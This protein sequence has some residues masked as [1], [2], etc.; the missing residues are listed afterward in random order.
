MSIEGQG[1]FLSLTQGRVHTKIKTYFFF[2]NYCAILNQI[3][4]ESFQVQ[5][6]ENVLT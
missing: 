6:N 4:R 5:G 2:K 1:H 3:L